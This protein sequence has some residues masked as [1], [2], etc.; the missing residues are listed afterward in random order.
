MGNTS[1]RTTAS[2]PLIGIR[3]D[4]GAGK[5]TLA[6]EISLC[7]PEYTIRKFATKLREAVSLI[8]NIPAEQTVSDVDKQVDLSG[9]PYVAL[10]LLQRIGKA[11]AHVTGEPAQ[12]SLAKQMFKVLTG[13]EAINLDATVYLSITVGRLLQVLGTECFR[14]FV[15]T[16]VWVDALITP[17]IQEGCPPVI[18]ADTRF[19]NESA[20]IRRAGGVIL[21][22]RRDSAGRTD[23]RSTGH[24][25]EHALDDEKPDFVIENSGTIADMREAFLAILPD[26][27]TL[28]ARR[29]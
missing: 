19:P 8:T 15:G 27:L 28:A 29:R 3:G 25:S 22:V 14:T 6:T 9:R 2:R 10:V 17:W 18:V 24:A 26:I 23:G 4:M 1:V 5:D 20:A 13:T 12:F 7:F 11:I 21:L 16:D